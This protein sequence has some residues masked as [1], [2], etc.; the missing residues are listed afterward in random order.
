MDTEHIKIAVKVGEAS[1]SGYDDLR[2]FE[3]LK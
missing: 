1:V 3:H 2:F